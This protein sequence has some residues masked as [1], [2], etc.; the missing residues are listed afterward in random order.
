MN[1]SKPILECVNLCKTFID[2]KLSV[3]VLKDINLQIHPGEMVA[4]I[5]ASGEGKSTL[6][7]LLGGLDN[8][9]SGHVKVYDKDITKLSETEKGLLRNKYLGFVYQFHHL[10]PEFNALENV[11]MPLLVR[12]L[13]P[14]QAKLKAKQLLDKVGLG[15]KLKRRIGEISGGE[16]QRIAIARAL[17]TD[18]I[19]VLA[20]EPTGN[21]DH[22][23]AEQIID[24]MLNLNKELQTSFLVATHDLTLANR[25]H[26]TLVLENATFK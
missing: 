22:R 1:N 23:T 17:V 14:K 11:C 15:Q 4:V 26:R 24:L 2:G 9:T 18:P 7:H 25:M 6:L 10:L 3:E 20:D 16:R 5:G 8:P 19:C 12:G 21:L 13:S